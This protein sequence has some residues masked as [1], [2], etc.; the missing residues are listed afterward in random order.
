M[1]LGRLIWRRWRLWATQN[2]EII[3][4]LR[5]SGLNP[6]KARV[7]KLKNKISVPGQK[8]SAFKI[9]VP[10]P[11]DIIPFR[12]ALSAA[13]TLEDECEIKEPTLM[14]QFACGCRTLAGR[15][16]CTCFVKDGTDKDFGDCAGLLNPETKER[17]GLCWNP[18]AMYKWSIK[19]LEMIKDAKEKAD[20]QTQVPVE[21]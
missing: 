18:T 4:K 7:G 3:V 10:Q 11:G 15:K 2:S 21:A 19:V 9:R 12:P 5:A 14:I 6:K 13:K 20:A 17:D 1:P 16:M 8:H